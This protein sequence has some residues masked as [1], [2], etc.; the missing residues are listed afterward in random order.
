MEECVS[1]C[2][3]FDCV[4]TGLAGF[5]GCEFLVVCLSDRDFSLC[6]RYVE[7][8]SGGE[9]EMVCGGPGTASRCDDG[10]GF[11]VVLAG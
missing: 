10:A 3:C 9:C 1:L 8:V 2:A 4:W 6:D 5:M 11:M 7:I